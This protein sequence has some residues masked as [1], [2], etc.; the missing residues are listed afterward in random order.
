MS[1]ISSLIGIL[2]IGHSLFGPTNPQMLSQVL[3][4][5]DVRVA[6]QIINGAPLSYQWDNGAKAEGVNARS[7]LPGGGFN[8]VIL[9]EGIPLANQMQYNDSIGSARRY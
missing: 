7:V 8:V 4:G 9:T 1:W 6:A 3:Q 5:R 2:F